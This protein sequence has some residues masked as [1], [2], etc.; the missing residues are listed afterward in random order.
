MRSPAHQ[1]FG[2]RLAALA[3]DA[4]SLAVIDRAG[5]ER[6]W[7]PYGQSWSRTY[8]R[9]QPHQTGYANL[10]FETRRTPQA[11]VGLEISDRRAEVGDGERHTLHDDLLGWVRLTRFPADP[12]LTTLPAVL[13]QA[14][15][16]AVVRYRPTRRC[17]I[18]VEEGDSIRFVKVFPDQDGA[19]IH[20]EGLEL[21]K[22]SAR[23]ELGFAV[24]RPDRWDPVA[25]ALWQ[26]RVPGLPLVSRLLGPDGDQVA[27][28]IG[29]ATASLTRSGFRPVQV[30]DGGAQMVRSARG[31]AELSRYVPALAGRA[32]KLLRQLSAIHAA[33]EARALRPIHGAPHANQWLEDGTRLGLVDFDR[34]SLGDPE[35]DVAVF[36]GELDFEVDLQLPA[37][38]LGDAFLA[39]YEAVAGPLDP[40]LLAA[41]RCHKRLAKVLRSARALRPDG[42]LR[43]ERNLGRAFDAL[44][45]GQGALP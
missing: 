26:H 36:L 27:D 25:R 10:L 37:E 33:A 5:R 8:G 43:A 6:D 21:W 14:P 45:D 24:A 3:D 16:A 40:T 9:F 42:D 17:T 34:V 44:A 20:A 38:R 7:W 2:T 11:I 29:R 32:Q 39:G 30:F 1:Q 15:R 22:A 41:Y 13:A 23:G 19:R 12:A 28:R 18:R 31:V 35:L 4:A